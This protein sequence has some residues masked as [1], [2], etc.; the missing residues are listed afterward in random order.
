VKKSLISL[1]RKSATAYLLPNSLED[2][3]INLDVDISERDTLFRE[4]EC[5]TCQQGSASLLQ[6]KLKL[7]YKSRSI[8]RPIKIL[9]LGP[10]EW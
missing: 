1:V 2:S 8:N 6:R 5:V 3:G 10:F 7:G 9:V 4:A